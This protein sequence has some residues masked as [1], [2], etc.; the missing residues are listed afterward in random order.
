MYTSHGH[1]IPGTVKKCVDFQPKNPKRCGG[2]KHCRVCMSETEAS[3]EILSRAPV[4]KTRMTSVTVPLVEYAEGERK[5]I[6]EALVE[7][8]DFEIVVSIASKS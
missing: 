8:D 1:H 5:M 4:T 6:G 7:F 3:N 2:V